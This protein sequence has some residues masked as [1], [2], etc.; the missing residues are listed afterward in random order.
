M[1]K[2]GKDRGGGGGGRKVVRLQLGCGVLFWS[3]VKRYYSMHVRE[4]GGVEREGGEV[5]VKG[6]GGGR[7]VVWNAGGEEEGKEWVQKI[8]VCFL[9]FVFCFLFFVFFL[10]SFCF[11]DF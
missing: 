8:R 10:I 4:V 5:V 11:F 1:K 3:S 6:M 2:K 9:F 7:E